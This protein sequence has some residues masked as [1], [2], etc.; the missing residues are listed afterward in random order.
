MLLGIG[1]LKHRQLHDAIGVPE[2]GIVVEAAGT[3][4]RAS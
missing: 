4:Q 1:G 3:E 2:Q